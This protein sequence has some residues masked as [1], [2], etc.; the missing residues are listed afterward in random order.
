MI[1]I[2]LIKN[3]FPKIKPSNLH[4]VILKTSISSYFRF[5]WLNLVIILEVIKLNYIGKSI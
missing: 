4:K 1:I 5:F 3:V 2:I